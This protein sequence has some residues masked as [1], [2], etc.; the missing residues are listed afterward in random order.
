MI[1]MK[2][3]RRIM[4]Q[5]RLEF[6]EKLVYETGALIRNMMASSLEIDTKSSANDFVT[7][8]DKA[9][10]QF[11]VEGILDAYPNQDFLTE[12]KTIER[13]ESDDLWIIDPIDGTL[14]FIYQRRNFAISIAYYHQKK[15]VFGIIYDVMRDEMVIGIHGEGVF[16]NGQ[17]VESRTHCTEKAK[18]LISIDDATMESVF[19]KGYTSDYVAHRYVG[20]AAIELC[21]VALGRTSLYIARTL[22]AWDV[23]AGM[24][25]VN[26][27]G[28]VTTDIGTG[29]F[30]DAPLRFVAAD[31]KVLLQSISED[32]HGYF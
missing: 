21:D 24:I 5:T 4:E 8:V 20:S 19:P 2:I 16:V 18:A 3:G 27:A 14:N 29:V 7:N 6:T 12:E 22:M 23:A 31:S 11:L 1:D 10:E 25:I 32:S 15:P 17:K 13:Q 26:E 28:G 9:A 30:E